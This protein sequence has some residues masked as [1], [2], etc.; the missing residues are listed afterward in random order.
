MDAWTAEEESAF[1]QLMTAGH[2][3]RMQAIRLFR[4]CRC[5][6]AKA[7]AIAKTNAPTVVRNRAAGQ[8]RIRRGAEKRS[9]GTF[10][11][12]RMHSGRLQA[13]AC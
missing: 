10:I 7:L 2:L 8:A 12:R 5:N 13:N 1:A 3:E 6:L 9:E 11:G 4:R